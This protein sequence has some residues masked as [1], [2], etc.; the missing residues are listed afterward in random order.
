MK[1][2]AAAARFRYAKRRSGKELR[3]LRPLS[4]RHDTDVSVPL[5]KFANLRRHKRR[6]RKTC[7]RNRAASI[8][9]GERGVA[10]GG[11]KRP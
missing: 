6:M 10:G 11:I 4:A 3:P 7:Y 8:I 1:G 2:D 5:Q 9:H